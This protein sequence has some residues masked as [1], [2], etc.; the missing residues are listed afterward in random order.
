MHGVEASTRSCK[1]WTFNLKNNIFQMIALLTRALV[2][3]K[4]KSLGKH[5]DDS[6]DKFK[7]EGN[8]T[9]LGV[10]FTKRR[11]GKCNEAYYRTFFYA[12][13]TVLTYFFYETFIMGKVRA[14]G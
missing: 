8:V 11:N 6:A 5:H 1:P 14:K 12:S 2:E 3:L 13:E 4:T 7:T 9:V 10:P